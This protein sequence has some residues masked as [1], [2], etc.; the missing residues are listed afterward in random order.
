MGNLPQHVER[1]PCEARAHAELS[2]HQTTHVTLTRAQLEYSSLH[3]EFRS[4]INLLSARPF[5]PFGTYTA[6]PLQGQSPL[7]NLEKSLIL[8]LR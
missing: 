7:R 8:L 1:G 2:D 6:S 3:P 4:V 5:L